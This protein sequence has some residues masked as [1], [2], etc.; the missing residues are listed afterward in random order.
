MEQS[1]GKG[2]EKKV[3][4]SSSNAEQSQAEKDDEV[5]VEQNLMD[6]KLRR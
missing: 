5:P 6:P 1:E 3:L 4:D 2:K